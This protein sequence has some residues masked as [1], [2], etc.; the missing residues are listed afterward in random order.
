MS[1]T[2]TGARQAGPVSTCRAPRVSAY[3]NSAPQAF[4]LPHPSPLPEDERQG[5]S[6][7]R[8]RKVSSPLT[9]TCPS[10]VITSAKLP[11]DLSLFV[12]LLSFLGAATASCLMLQ[13]QLFHY[14]LTVS[15][16]EGKLFEGKSCILLICKC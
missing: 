7:V 9:L 8:N 4:Y 14:I 13:R 2:R 16:L 11:T 5:L 6:E 15:S 12:S 1:R 10:S 3:L